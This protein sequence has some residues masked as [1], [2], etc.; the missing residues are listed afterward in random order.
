MSFWA[1]VASQINGAW[2]EG[3]E[4]VHILSQPEYFEKPEAYFNIFFLSKQ[5][6]FTYEKLLT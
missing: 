1:M 4:T 3:G 2:G 6:I 5:F